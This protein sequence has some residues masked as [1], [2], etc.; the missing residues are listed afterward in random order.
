MQLAFFFL[1]FLAKSFF[2]LRFLHHNSTS[3]RKNASQRVGNYILRCF[4]A[5]A[6]GAGGNLFGREFPKG[7]SLEV[8]LFAFFASFF[9]FLHF[10]HCIF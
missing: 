6:E 2:F 5:G 8:A 1:H 4:Y 7:I 9:Q 10:L 3:A